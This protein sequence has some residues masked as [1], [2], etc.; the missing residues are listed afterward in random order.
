MKSQSEQRKFS[1]S[2]FPD[3]GLWNADLRLSVKKLEQW[4]TGVL[5]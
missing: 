4:S 2:P 5:E 3:F 1:F